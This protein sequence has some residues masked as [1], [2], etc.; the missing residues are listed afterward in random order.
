MA[1]MENPHKT[2]PVTLTERVRRGELVAVEC[3]SRGVLKHLTGL[4]AV[5]ILIALREVKTL[6][7][8]ELR[9]KATGV[10]EKMLTQTLQAL[11]A[12]GIVDRKAYP[13]VPPHVEYSLTPLG[14]EA[15]D[16]VA[17]LADW[18]ETRLP[19]VMQARRAAR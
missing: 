12:D 15:A 14:R 18:V 16:Q 10:S 2:D 17:A 19:K 1:T 8:S 13:V 7:F 4:W 6:R 11:E 9:R 5:L 3:P